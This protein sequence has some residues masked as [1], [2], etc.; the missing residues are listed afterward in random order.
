MSE[1]TFNPKQF[2]QYREDNRLE[3][4]AANGGLPGTLWDDRVLEVFIPKLI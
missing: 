1:P 3:A 4:K 2:N